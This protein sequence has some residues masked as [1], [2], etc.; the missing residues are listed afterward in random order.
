MIKPAGTISFENLQTHRLVRGGGFTKDF[1][2]QGRAEAGIAILGQ[3]GDIDDTPLMA[4]AVKDEPSCVDSVAQDDLKVCVGKRT[5]ITLA[6]LEL[7]GEEGA[8]HFRRPT[9]GVEFFL[10]GT[11][12]QLEE[13]RLILRLFGAEGYRIKTLG[14]GSRALKEPRPKSHFEKGYTHSPPTR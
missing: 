9:P 14:H 12:V 1:L 7:Q 4:G 3:E 11:S 13:E 2:Q 5:V 10:A 8:A 6:G